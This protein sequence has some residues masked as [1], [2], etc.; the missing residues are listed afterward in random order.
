MKTLTAEAVVAAAQ[1]KKSV[2]AVAKALG[3]KGNP[4]GS[5]CK[6]IRALVPNLAD[7]LAGTVTVA[8]PQ[9]AK[10]SMAG[11]SK[12]AEAHG[13]FK[14]GSKIAIVFSIGNKP[15]FHSLHDILVEAANTPTFKA[16]VGKDGKPLD[17]GVPGKTPTK[18]DHNGR[19]GMA[20]WQYTM[21]GSKHPTNNGRVA[22]VPQD[23]S[24]K[25][26]HD[27]KIRFELVES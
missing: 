22:V 5:L 3:C 27:R 10:P 18:E 20:Y 16:E 6:K 8:A 9:K 14:A 13:P 4:S 12:A 21:L 2:S 24:Q 15:G 19:Y 26:G 25:K 11:K 1:G 7:I 17:L 23:P